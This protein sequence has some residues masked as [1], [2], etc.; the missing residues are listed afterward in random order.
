MTAK[1]LMVQGTGSSVGKS[2][3]VTALC[4]I[5]KQQGLKVAPFKAQNM[6]LNSFVTPDGEEIGRAQ[7]VQAEAS[8]IPA[9]IDMNPVLLKPEADN[10]S[11]IIVGGKPLTK[12]SAA[13]FPRIKSLL[14]AAISESLDR[15]RERF[16]VVV[17]EGAGSPAEINLRDRDLVNM[18]VALYCDSPVLLA[19][20]IDRGGVFASLIGTMQLLEESEKEHIKAFIINK[21]RGDISLLMPGVDWLENRTGVPVAGVIPYYH[22]IYI[23]EE[24]SMPVEKRRAMKQRRE[25]GIDVAVIALPHIANFDDFDPLEREVG[26]GLR[27]VEA[28]DDLGDPDLIILP[29]SKTTVTDLSYLKENARDKEILRHVERGKPIIGI[30]GGYQML[31][32]AIH[33]PGGIESSTATTVGLS[34]LPVTSRFLTRKATRQISA[35][36]LVDRGLLAKAKNIMVQGYEIHMGLTTGSSMLNPFE[37]TQRGSQTC[38]DLEGC[39]SP[40]GNVLGTYIHGLFHNDDFRWALLHK[41]AARKGQAFTPLIGSFSIEEQYDRLAAHVRDSLDM[42]LIQRLIA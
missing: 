3:L 22:D 39:M 18:E 10:C 6:S 38:A 41:L 30:C 36:V 34:L 4:R 19:A 20:D 35:R 42:D 17:I 33:D 27:Y 26:V 28:G 16:D 12:V 25:L 21:F 13:D 7:A 11:Q 1:T 23:P 14:W 5:F 2:V 37:V 40:D 15:L 29:G 32:L 9:N 8:G 31:G 24:D